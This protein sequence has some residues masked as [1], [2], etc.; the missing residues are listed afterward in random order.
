MNVALANTDEITL[1]KFLVYSL[2]LHALLAAAIAASIIYQYKGNQ[3]LGTGSTQ[4]DV[5]V[6]LVAPEAAGI[7]MPKPEVE[8]ASKMVDPTKSLYKEEPKPP[9]IPEPPQPELKIPKFKDDLKPKPIVHPSKEFVDA[10]RD[11]PRNAVR[12]G[13]SGAPNIP[14]GYGTKPGNPNAGTNFIGQGGGD[15]ATRYGWY[16]EAVRRKIASNW[17]QFEIDPG[18]RAARKAHAVM[19]F[20]IYKDG[21]VKNI[22]LDQTSGNQS[23]DTSAQR[24]LLSA[25][26]MPPLP[27]DYSGSYVTVIFD[28]DLAMMH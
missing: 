5:K 20:A 8:T 9:E 13:Q 6:S 3:W 17:N 21:S 11:V 14:T 23:M 4:G 12:T 25:S 24:A 18:V 22:R 7:P 26:P 1:K 10:P 28:F 27:N 15:F 16:I 19:T 2:V